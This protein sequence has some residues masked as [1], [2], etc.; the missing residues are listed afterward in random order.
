M[1]RAIWVAPLAFGLAIIAAPAWA[2]CVTGDAAQGC[3][4]PFSNYNSSQ[5]PAADGMTTRQGF[6]AQTGSQ[7]SSTTQKAGDFTFYSGVS[8]GNSWAGR[9]RLYGN[10]L[11]GPGFGSQDQSDSPQCAFYGNCH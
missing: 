7:W 1:R 4:L 2:F 8:S 3:P 10:G 5:Q 11:N 9:Q 6:D